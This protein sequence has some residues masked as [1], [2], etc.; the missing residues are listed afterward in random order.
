MNEKRGRKPSRVPTP[1]LVAGAQGDAVCYGDTEVSEV[2][3][4]WLVDVSTLNGGH[5]EVE[6][7]LILRF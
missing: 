2:G 4:T 3:P 7:R 1:L 6:S 5:K